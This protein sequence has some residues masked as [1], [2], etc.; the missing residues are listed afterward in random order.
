MTWER[1]R[2]FI[3]RSNCGHLVSGAFIQCELLVYHMIALIVLFPTSLLTIP[4]RYHGVL[5]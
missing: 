1:L 4:A 5:S 2:I 3:L